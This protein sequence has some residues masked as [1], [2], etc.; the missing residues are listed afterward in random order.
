MW[1]F[2]VPAMLPDTSFFSEI[3]VTNVV[4]VS[5]LLT[6]SLFHAFFSVSTVDFE[7]LN[8]FWIACQDL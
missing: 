7:Q 1:L 4:L 5:L 3:D 2:G 8:V 6:L